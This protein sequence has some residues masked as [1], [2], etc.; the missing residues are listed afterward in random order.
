MYHRWRSHHPL[1][2]TQLIQETSET[3]HVCLVIIRVAGKRFLSIKTSPTPSADVLYDGLIDF[4]GE[5]YPLVC[6]VS[7]KPYEQL[8]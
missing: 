6:S 4:T 2:R 1:E 3:E 7:A 5:S 8:E